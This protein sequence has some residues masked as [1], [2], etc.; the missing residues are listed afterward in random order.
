MYRGVRYHVL[1]LKGRG[2]FY[3]GRDGGM[4]EASDGHE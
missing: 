2:S 3:E 1:G 4:G